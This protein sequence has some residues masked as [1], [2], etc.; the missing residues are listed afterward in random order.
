VK[1]NERNGVCSFIG[2]NDAAEMTGR[3][4]DDFFGADLRAAVA[5]TVVFFAAGLVAVV[6]VAGFFFVV[7]INILTI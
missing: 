1:L 6:F 2:R 7:A 4:A 5:F 3:L